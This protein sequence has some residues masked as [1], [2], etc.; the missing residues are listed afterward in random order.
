MLGLGLL[1]SL[2]VEVHGRHFF[3]S[4]AASA[5]VRDLETSGYWFHSRPFSLRPPVFGRIPPHCLKKNAMFWARHWSRIFSAHSSAIGR[6]RGPLSPPRIAQ[7]MP[8]KSTF[9]TGPINGSNEIN[10]TVACAARR[11]LMRTT[12]CLSSTD[13]PS[14]TCDGALLVG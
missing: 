1:A 3:Y 14:Q 8:V 6:A 2:V 13:T 7:S 9:P 4:A 12:F 5:M 11:C 10:F